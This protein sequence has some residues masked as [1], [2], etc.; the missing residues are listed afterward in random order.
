MT[1]TDITAEIIAPAK[2]AIPALALTIAAAFHYLPPS[3]FLIPDAHTRRE[4]FPITFGFDVAD[5]MAH[6]TV[7]ALRGNGGVALWAQVPVG[8]PPEAQ[9]DPRLEQIDGEMARRY[10]QFYRVLGACHPRESAHHHLMILAVRPDLA[11]KGFGSALL[12]QHHTYLDAVAQPAYLEAG[13]ERAR[14]LYLRHGYLDHGEPIRLPV[15]TGLMYPM[16]REPRPV[17]PV[18]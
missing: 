9:R 10:M 4:R 11:G 6:G 5:A 17:V 12:N 13:S 7:Y 1:G 15:G 16:W 2:A 18:E 8:G 14:E 3:Q